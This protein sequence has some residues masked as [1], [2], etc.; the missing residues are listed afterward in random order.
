MFSPGWNLKPHPTTDDQSNISPM[1][2]KSEETSPPPPY[3]ATPAEESSITSLQ[4]QDSS[5]IHICGDNLQ[6]P[7]SHSTTLY[8]LH[9]LSQFLLYTTSTYI[10]YIPCRTCLLSLFSVHTGPAQ[11]VWCRAYKPQMYRDDG[12]A[13]VP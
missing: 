9:F 13:Q 3:E 10:L 12:L 2:P 11:L 8:K 6:F 4:R 1:A 7:T 5:G